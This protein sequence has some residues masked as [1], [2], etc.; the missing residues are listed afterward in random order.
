MITKHILLPTDFSTNARN[1]IDYAIYLFEKEECTFYIMNAFQV[2]P[3]G[4]SSTINKAKD[5]RLHR[6]IKA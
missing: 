3:S 5:T 6:A 1:A 4:L 2:S